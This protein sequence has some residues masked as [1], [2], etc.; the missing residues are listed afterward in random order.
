MADRVFD[1]LDRHGAVIFASAVPCGAA[2]PPKD[3]PP[4]PDILRKDYTFLLE[5]F[6]YFLEYHRQ[7]GLLVMDEVEKTEDRRFVQRL[8]DYF[9]KTANG[10]ARSKWIVPAPFFVASDMAL[11]V[12]IADV[13]TYA[14][15]WGL[16][17]SGGNDRADP[18]GSREPLRL[19][20]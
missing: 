15:N 14:L 1:L 18:S 17:P 20:D 11:P 9:V 16:P 19:T 7:M 13:V 4:S 12:Q 2:R 6:F 10:R 5:R 8:H 3:A